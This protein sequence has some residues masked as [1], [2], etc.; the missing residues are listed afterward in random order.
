M[1]HSEERRLHYAR[2]GRAFAEHTFDL[3]RN[4]RWLTER[5]RTTQRAACPQ[6]GQDGQTD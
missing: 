6:G 1:L 3:W 4:G 5:L 2:V